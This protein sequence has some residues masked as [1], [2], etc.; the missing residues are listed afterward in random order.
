M[1]LI[2]PVLQDILQFFNSKLKKRKKLKKLNKIKIYF[3]ISIFAYIYL[4]SQQ[5]EKE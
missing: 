4:N 2:H 5:K 1:T 3:Y